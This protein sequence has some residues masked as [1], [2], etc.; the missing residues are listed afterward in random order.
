MSY[1]GKVELE[2]HLL[3]VIDKADIGVIGG[4]GQINDRDLGVTLL[5]KPRE[6]DVQFYGLDE[7]PFGSR[8]FERTIIGRA[9]LQAV[10][11][12]KEKITDAVKPPSLPEGVVGRVV[13]ISD[14]SSSVYLNLGSDDG[15]K[16]GDKFIVYSQGEMLL[17]PV[18]GESLGKLELK[19]GVVQITVVNAAH[20][21]K[22]TIVITGEAPIERGSIA[23]PEGM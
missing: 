8:E 20:L 11:E 16:M 3:R 5:G 12:L 6:K 15:V 1:Q 18:T 19:A 22:A 10:D 14:D 9:A 2:I 21:S 17:D 23:R 4:N 13:S 7:I